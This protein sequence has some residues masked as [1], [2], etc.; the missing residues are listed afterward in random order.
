ME[1]WCCLQPQEIQ[2]WDENMPASPA[3]QKQIRASRREGSHEGRVND[4]EKELIMSILPETSWSTSSSTAWPS[5]LMPVVTYSCSGCSW[6]TLLRLWNHITEAS[7]LQSTPT[8][9]WRNMSSKQSHLFRAHVC[10]AH[11]LQGCHLCAA[12]NSSDC[13]KSWK[14]FC[15]FTFSFFN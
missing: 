1:E 2:H 10:E 11:G 9:L 3:P 14:P 12:M 6:L 5:P 8:H 4:I 13:C 15:G 7:H